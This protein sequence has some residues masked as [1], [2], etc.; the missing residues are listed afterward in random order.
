VIFGLLHP[1]TPGY[2]LIA[3]LMGAYLGGLWMLNGNLLTVMVAHALYDFVA[4]VLLLREK[5]ARS[6]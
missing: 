2:I 4:L 6:S 5:P 1:I 3:G